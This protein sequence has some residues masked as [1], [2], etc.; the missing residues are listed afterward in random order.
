MKRTECVKPSAGRSKVVSLLLVAVI[1]L[2]AFAIGV[3]VNAKPQTA[4]NA[5]T[6]GTVTLHVYDPTQKY[7]SLAGW[8]WLKGGSGKEYSIASAAAPD[9]QFYKEYTEN[10]KT[11]RNTSRR[12]EISFTADEI[13][14]LKS[15]KQMG[16]LVCASTGKSDTDFWKRYQK[17]TSDIFV[18]LTK[19]FDANNH[20]DIYYVRKDK[21]AYTVL[22]EAIKTL[23]KITS[24]RFTE[25]TAATAT[26]PATATVEF[27]VTTPLNQ[28]VTA[29]LYNGKNRITTAAVE[30]DKTNKCLGTATFETEFD[31]TVDYNLGASG[32]STTCPIAKT[33]FID[34]PDFIKAYE[35][36]DTQDQQYGAIYSKNS[37]TFR[38]WAPFATQVIVKLFAS[39]SAAQHEKAYFMTK[40]VP[41]SG[42]W[43]GVW[44]TTVNGD[45]NGKYYTYA[46]NNSG[47][48]TETIDPYAKACGANGLRGMVVDLN[49]TNPAGWTADKDWYKKYSTNV[50]TP[51][52]W[53]VT[54]SDFSSSADSG[55]KYKG[56]Y[57]AFTESGTTVPGKPNL[58]TGVD[59]L[60]E[61]GITYVHLN[62]VYDFATVDEGD[63]T[64]ADS[65]AF[66]WGYD[67]QNYNIP[68]GSYST[69]PANGAVRI[70]E[71]KR[72]VKALHDAGI[73]VVMDVVYNHTFSTGGQALHDTVPYY[74]HRTDGN[75]EFTNGSGC[76]NETASERTMM[77]KYIVDSMVYWAE[78]Y[79]IDGF[80]FDLMGVHDLDTIKAVRTA[81]DNVN[82]KTGK[83]ILIY[84]EP[85]SADG[86]YVPPS[87]S[88]R[89][90]VSKSGTGITGYAIN[91]ASNMLIK[92]M[93]AGY[94]DDYPRDMTKLPDRVAV[95][96]DTGREGLRG[97]ND[98]GK[99]WAN[100]APGMAGNVARMMEG[101]AG[102]SGSGMTLGAGSR[103]V[104]YACAHDNFTLWDQ[105]RGAKQGAESALYYDAPVADD[106][107]KCKLVA[108]AYM[109]S[110]GMCFMIAG[111]EMARTKYGNENSYNSPVKLNQIT[112]SRQETFS[113]LHN[114]YA[115]LIALRKQYS[116]QL[117]S[118]SES[119]KASFCWG[120]FNG[121][122]DY[123]TGAIS[124]SRTQ[125][126]ATLTV[127]LTPSSTP[128]GTVKIGSTTL[129]IN[130]KY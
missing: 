30:V 23:E 9:E 16:F 77:R 95:F 103:N 49:A 115:K 88:N 73:G 100:G 1:A 55:M 106:I 127:N 126:G 89:V 33:A 15:D 6:A 34:E 11:V 32:I 98:P 63:M 46:I 57:L 35:S 97:N 92:N 87:Y 96:N 65:G 118:Y 43:G 121:G 117:F 79:H 47:A 124:F 18:D 101:G 119:T 24:A 112:W 45:L 31:F 56:K 83:R 52:I 19:A 28:N 108:S 81:L 25:K 110:T 104:A 107:K 67:P 80:R 62:P 12:I 66:N 70:N 76:G 40:R 74:Y 7:T 60:K 102:G 13:A 71:F 86:C 54:V 99:G 69:D 5:E 38:V 50:D 39:G 21:K 84:G 85:W 128:V 44:E 22:E 109:M 42:E 2:M 29:T 78:E 58:K 26:K 105:I 93:F 91:T 8:V 68:E 116:S 36:K 113:D 41:T 20:A 14:A 51:I 64:R 53:E 17:E 125:N 129:N 27:E 10:G 94:K 72:M 4:P 90:A 114:Y 120:N 75:G 130:T 59:Y 122:P 111:E 61:L 37:T 123:N 3:F 82:G 48:D